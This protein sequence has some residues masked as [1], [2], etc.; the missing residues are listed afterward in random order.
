M[1]IVQCVILMCELSSRAIRENNKNRNTNE[2]HGLLGQMKCITYN[3]YGIE[4]IVSLYS[5]P[6]GIFIVFVY[7]INKQIV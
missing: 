3:I 6:F 2:F 1:G 5:L 4:E 7:K